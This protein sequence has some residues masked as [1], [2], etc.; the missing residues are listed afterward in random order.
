[1][2]DEAVDVTYGL[3][4]PQARRWVDAALLRD[5]GPDDASFASSV[6]AGLDDG[7]LTHMSVPD[8]NRLH[9]ISGME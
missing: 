5:L 4:G 2:N 8:W 1:M 6:A 3:N 9:E 7:S